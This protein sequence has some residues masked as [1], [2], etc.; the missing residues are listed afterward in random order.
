MQWITLHIEH[1][2][3][4]TSSANVPGEHGVQEAA[5]DWFEKKP[6]LHTEHFLMPFSIA[7]VPGEQGSQAAALALEKK[8]GK[9][10]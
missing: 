1:L 10:F 5:A 6:A 8:P 4:P 9:H 3:M 7:N 2:F